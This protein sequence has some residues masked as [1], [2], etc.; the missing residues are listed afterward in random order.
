MVAEA[1]EYFR[2]AGKK[3]SGILTFENFKAH[4]CPSL[5]NEE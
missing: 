2:Q 3:Q 4:D 1:E 5:D